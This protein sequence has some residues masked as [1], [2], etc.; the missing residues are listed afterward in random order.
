M[1]KPQKNFYMAIQWLSKLDSYLIISKEFIVI[2]HL[3][4]IQ[5]LA[6]RMRSRS[7]HLLLFKTGRSW[8]QRLFLSIQAEFTPVR[9]LGTILHAGTVLNFPCVLKGTMFSMEQCS[10]WNIMLCAI[11][12]TV[13]YVLYYQLRWRALFNSCIQ[14]SLSKPLSTGGAFSV[15]RHSPSTPWEK[16]PFLVYKVS[17]KIRPLHRVR[18]MNLDM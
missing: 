7:C 11:L 1:I 13:P 14:L 9:F 12:L 17:Q 15:A 2:D 16:G 6:S 4:S 10:Q 3:S 8:I 18:D 5:I